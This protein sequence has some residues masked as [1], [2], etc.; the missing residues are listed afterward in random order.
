M[1]NRAGSLILVAVA[2]AVALA[3]ASMA[4]L[5]AGLAARRRELRRERLREANRAAWRP[6]CQD[7]SPPCA[8]AEA[9][10]DTD[11]PAQ[12]GSPLSPQ[13][14]PTRDI[15]SAPHPR[16]ARVAS[17]YPAHNHPAKMRMMELLAFLKDLDA[18]YRLER[19]I[20]RDAKLSP[21]FHPAQGSSWASSS[22]GSSCLRRNFE[23]GAEPQGSLRADHSGM[24]K[25]SRCDV[26]PQ[27]GSSN[28]SLRLPGTPAGASAAR[29]GS[30]RRL[31]SKHMSKHKVVGCFAGSTSECSSTADED[32]GA[33]VVHRPCAQ[34]ANACTEDVAEHVSIGPTRIRP[35]L[36]CATQRDEQEHQAGEYTLARSSDGFGFATPALDHNAKRAHLSLG[37][38]AK[39]FASGD[40][41]HHRPS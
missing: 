39:S 1:A 6:C 26:R 35:L 29:P 36:D 37:A 38:C 12:A 14:R 22:A 34:D 3:N 9:N 41:T 16:P 2:L 20:L 24:K 15:T 5:R 19:D 10:E 21:G 4:F 11:A 8:P 33:D 32:A 30:N 25:S 40:R 27:Q 28:S 13:R 23:D 18:K 7:A 31:R 17:P